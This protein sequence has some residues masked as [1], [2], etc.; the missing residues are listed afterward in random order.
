MKPGTFKVRFWKNARLREQKALDMEVDLDYFTNSQPLSLHARPRTI[1][2][3]SLDK[4]V[5][6]VVG[7]KSRKPPPGKQPLKKTQSFYW[8]PRVRRHAICYSLPNTAASIVNRHLP[9]P[10]NEGLLLVDDDDV[11]ADVVATSAQPVQQVCDSYVN[12]GFTVLRAL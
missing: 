8:D 5:S 9:G 12:I 3:S 11:A 4:V 7:K 2:T 6:K 1:S 10:N